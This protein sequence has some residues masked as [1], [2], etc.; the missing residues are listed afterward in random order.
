[1]DKVCRLKDWKTEFRSQN[2]A[3]RRQMKQTRGRRGKTGYMTNDKQ[4]I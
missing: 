3:V 2:S 1:M 4:A